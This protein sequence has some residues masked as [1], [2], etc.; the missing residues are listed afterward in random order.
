M[1]A[2]GI[3]PIPNLLFTKKATQDPTSYAVN[4]DAAITALTRIAGRFAPMSWPGAFGTSMTAL[5][6]PGHLFNG[7]TLTEVGGRSTG[8]FTSGSASVAS[9]GNTTGMLVGMTV[10]AFAFNSINITANTTN[11]SP[12]LASPS[13]TTGLYVG[14]PVYGLG[15]P[16]GATITAIGASIT[17][18]ANATATATGVSIL[19]SGLAPAV[20]INTVITAVGTTTLTLSQ[21]ALATLTGAYIFVCQQVGKVTTGNITN[22]SAAVSAIPSTRGL[23][24]GLSITGTGIPINTTILNVVDENNITLSANATATTTGVA[25]TS[26]ILAPGANSRIDLISINQG[27]G[28]INYTAGTAAATPSPPA[29]PAGYLP[30]AFLLLTNTSTTIGTADL[31]DARD[32]SALGLGTGAYAAAVTVPT[33]TLGMMF[34]ASV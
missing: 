17:I 3:T 24:P 12:T 33:L 4:I 32:L 31:S 8:N 28:R 2:Q 29:I 13:S 19:A 6:A 7:T 15:I 20:P 18:S 5:L 22:G 10:L 9:V 23:F 25:L 11:G 27:T 30:A 21:N 14:M 16:P 26:A 1:T 34:G